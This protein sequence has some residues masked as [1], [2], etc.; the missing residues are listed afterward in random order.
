MQITKK[1]SWPRSS[2]YIS[3]HEQP[4]WDF[5]GLGKWQEAEELIAH[6]VEASSRILRKEPLRTMKSINI[7]A[8]AYKKQRRWKDSEVLEVQILETSKK[9][10]NQNHPSTLCIIN[11]L[12][13]TFRGQGR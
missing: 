5:V 12:A 8:A 13:R 9:L 1:D 6:I 10:C 3:Q 7:L 2:R 4:H 11:N